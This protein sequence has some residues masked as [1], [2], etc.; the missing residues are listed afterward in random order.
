MTTRG[1]GPAA[2]H[3]ETAL[4][5]ILGGALGNVID[6]LQ[7]GYVV[8]FIQLHYGGRAFP[9]FN[10]AD[11]AI[12]LGAI[13]PVLAFLRWALAERAM[14]HN[15]PLPSLG[16]SAAVITGIVLV[17]AAVLAVVVAGF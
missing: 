5:M 15:A 2:Q 12:T 17:A 10:V 11:S 6:R 8:D 13:C 7:H 1:G 9:S 16:V 14:R 4:T 3:V